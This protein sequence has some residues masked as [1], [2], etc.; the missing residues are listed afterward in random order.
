MGLLQVEADDLVEFDETGAA[1]LHP[2]CEAPMQVGPRRLGQGL[3]GGIPH[4]QMPE[5]KGVLAGELRGVWPDQ[6]Y[7][8]QRGKAS[9]CPGLLGR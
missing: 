7:A 1:F 9:R 5:S 8:D 6:P 4:Q 2:E 3:V